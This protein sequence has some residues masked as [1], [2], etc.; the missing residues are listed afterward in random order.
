M[1]KF[2]AEKGRDLR[3]DFL[4]F[5]RFGLRQIVREKIEENILDALGAIELLR[6]F[7]SSVR[8]AKKAM[9]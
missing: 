2:I 7:M 9:R 8:M 1:G 5:F 6:V 4:A 3:H